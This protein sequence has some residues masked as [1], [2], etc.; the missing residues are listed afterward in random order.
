ML[1][2]STSSVGSPPRMLLLAEWA[3]I[4]LTRSSWKDALVAAVDFKVPRIVIYQATCE[5]LEAV[6]R[7][8][9]AV[10][11]F[12]QMVN[13]L[14]IRQDEEPEWAQ[15]FKDRCSQKL[16][17]H[18]DAAMKAQQHDEAILRYSAALA[19]NATATPT[20]LVK[21]S[22]TYAEKGLWK[23]ALDDADNI[24]SLDPS[25]PKGHERKH[26]ALHKAG[27]YRDAIT[28]FETMLSSMLQ[29]SDPGVR[30]RSGQFVKPEETKAKICIAVQ[31]AVRDLPRVLIDT[32]S[33][34]LLDHSKLAA[35]FKSSPV[36]TELVSSM[37]TAIH[38]DR[39]EHEVA[40][41]YHYAAFS[42][43][44]EENEPLFANVVHIAAYDL[45]E[46]P[47]HDKLQMFCKIARDAGFHWAWSDN[48]CINKQDHVVLQEALVTMFKWYE[49]SALVI[50]FLRGVRSP[51]KR[52]DLVRSIWNTRAWTF[53]EYHAA[54]VV[55]FYT[56]DWKPYRDLD[57]PNHKESPEIISEMEEATRISARALRE[58]RPGLN[59]IRTKLSLASQ[60]KATFVEDIA[61]SLFGIF[62]ISLPIVYGE[63]DEALGRLLAHL[64]ASSGDTGILAWTGKSGSFN[65][66]FPADITVFDQSPTL[67]T[68]SALR[69]GETTADTS[70]LHVSSLN[71]TADM[72]MYDLL[73]GLPVP[74]LSGKR[75]KIP[76]ITF[77]LGHP[78][79]TS[80][81]CNVYRAK[82]DALETVTIT[83]RE[84]L[85]QLDSAFLIHPWIDS[86]LDKQPVGGGKN[87]LSQRDTPVR[88]LLRG[89]SSD[90]HPAPTVVDRVKQS[91]LARRAK[92]IQNSVSH[93]SSLPPPSLE[94][95][96]DRQMQVLQFVARVRQPFG[97]LLV[98]PT[99]DNVKAYRRI[100]VD[101][102]ITVRI[103]EDVELDD[104]IPNVQ[105][106]DML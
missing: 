68:P 29:S 77:K 52:G 12:C 46:S 28:S 34:H 60:R 75:I 42:H 20:L 55:R 80:E 105:V 100:A 47:T 21:R 17:G 24:I 49:G 45:E 38:D 61:Y 50:V 70:R 97:A 5:C 13:E 4:Q 16:D 48:S 56:E 88:P 27:H 73:S 92:P 39:I 82:A 40:Q 94:S 90:P 58:L 30:E 32:A 66:C 62:S 14:A 19:L 36:F 8:T 106:L 44:W 78:R 11:C 84:D 76:C 72:R 54:K 67:Y 83:T 71:S 25:S 74:S 59:D 26:A 6:D 22:E 79:R 102:L 33:G 101:S 51:S 1:Y 10:D 15:G 89:Q 65:S 3:R 53:Q 64:L 69:F 31:D 99:L 63:G 98:T 2:S 41:F 37:T 18:G 103:Q 96:T 81:D 43:T 104:L 91:F 95:L 93:S 7:L 57:I 86:L 9:E 85:S 23:E 87:V 35:K